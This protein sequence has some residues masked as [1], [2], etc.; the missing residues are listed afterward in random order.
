MLEEANRWLVWYGVLWM[1]CDV[2]WLDAS[3]SQQSWIQSI[4]ITTTKI[5]IYSGKKFFQHTL[6]EIRSSFSQV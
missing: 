4:C 5:N 3:Y 1:V 6:S 2:E